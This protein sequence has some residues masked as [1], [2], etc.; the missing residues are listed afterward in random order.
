MNQLDLFLKDLTEDILV[1]NAFAKGF[2]PLAI[3]I[4]FVQSFHSHQQNKLVM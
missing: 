2:N 4:R 1:N 3:P